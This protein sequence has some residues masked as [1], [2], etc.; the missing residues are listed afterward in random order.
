M[1]D[2]LV[3]CMRAGVI[4]DSVFMGCCMC[5]VACLCALHPSFLPSGDDCCRPE[6][7][8]ILLF[9][10]G[11]FHILFVSLVQCNVF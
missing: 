3:L 9:P 5:V 7:E 11:L 1:C 4:S 8:K 10:V 2:L 6:K